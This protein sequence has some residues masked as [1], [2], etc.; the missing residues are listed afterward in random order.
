MIPA[1]IC[2]S[3][4][5]MEQTLK[6]YTYDEGERP[7]FH[8]PELNGIYA[9]EGWFMKQLQENKQFVTQNPDKA[10]LYYLPFS[11]H[12]LQEVLYVPSSH[13]RKN[14]VRYLNSYLHNI[15]TM[16][17][18]WNRANGADHFLVACHD[19]VRLHTFL[20]L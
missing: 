1:L 11:S 7:I 4:D 12:I 17:P 18:F 5:L 2:R 16:Y 19:W 8:E 6:I 10:H 13:S 9:S 14:L 3:Y 20:C 15:I